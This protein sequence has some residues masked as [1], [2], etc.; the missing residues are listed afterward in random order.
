MS[1]VQLPF[2]MQDYLPD[3]CYNKELTERALSSVFSS[4]GYKKVCVPTLE[5]YDLFTADDSISGKKLFKLT[6]PF[7]EDLFERYLSAKVKIS[8]F[9]IGSSI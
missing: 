3:D 2:G 6:D 7:D 9:F 5:Y 4:Y 1:K 8:L